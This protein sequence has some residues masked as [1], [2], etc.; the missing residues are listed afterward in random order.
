MAETSAKACE[1]DTRRHVEPNVDTHLQTFQAMDVTLRIEKRTQ[2]TIPSATDV[3][4]V[5]PHSCASIRINPRLTRG[6]GVKCTHFFTHQASQR[7]AAGAPN[8]QYLSQTKRS[9][10]WKSF[11]KI[12]SNF[13]D[14]VFFITSWFY[15]FTSKTRYL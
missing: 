1:Q 13:L 7:C 5:G 11:T 14:V 2:P 15:I 12:S 4:Y 6:G 9:L 8:F 10:R 3:G